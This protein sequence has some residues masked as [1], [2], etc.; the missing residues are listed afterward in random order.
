MV[1]SNGY[2]IAVNLFPANRHE[3]ALVEETIE[4]AL[5]NIKK[6]KNLIGNTAYSS[7]PLTQ[8]LF[9]RWQIQLK[10]PLKRNYVNFFHDNRR[11]RRSKR[12]WKVEEYFAWIKY[13][14]RIHY[15]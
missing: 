14:L 1:D 3:P 11:L 15:R 9:N 8:K 7:R 2:P 13:H 10:G 12:R 4:Y 6:P 5:G